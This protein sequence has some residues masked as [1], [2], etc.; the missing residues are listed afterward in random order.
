MK[1]K[2]MYVQMKDENMYVQMKDENM[3]VQMKDK[4]MYVQMKDKNSI[5]KVMDRKREKRSYEGNTT[6]SYYSKYMEPWVSI[7]IMAT[8][9][10]YEKMYDI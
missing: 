7:G 2:N 5:D 4:N 9:I 10:K 1:D 6:I 3:Y 8:A